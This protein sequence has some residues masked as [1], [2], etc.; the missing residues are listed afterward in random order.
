M[1]INND[2]IYKNIN[3]D[4]LSINLDNSALKTIS[5]FKSNRK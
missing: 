4:F 3:F 5:L 2:E 1:K